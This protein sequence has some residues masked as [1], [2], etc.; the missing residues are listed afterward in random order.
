MG[1][2]W[3]G[4][5]CIDHKLLLTITI[6]TCKCYSIVYNFEIYLYLEINIRR[7]MAYVNSGNNNCYLLNI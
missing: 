4:L 6:A 5:I 3:F 2:L 7:K 1:K